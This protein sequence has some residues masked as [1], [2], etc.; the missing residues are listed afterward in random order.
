MAAHA[1]GRPYIF[2]WLGLLGLTLLSFGLDQLQLGHIFVLIALVIAVVKAS[3]VFW[4]FMHLNREPF[5]IRFIAAL[6]VAWVVLLCAGI[7]ADVGT[8]AP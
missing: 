6:N 7:A 1:S 5:P 8:F 4:I 3:I 2:A